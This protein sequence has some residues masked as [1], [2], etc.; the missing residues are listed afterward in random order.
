MPT[1]WLT[2]SHSAPLAQASHGRSSSPGITPAATG[3]VTSHVLPWFDHLVRTRY[4][5]AVS[6]MYTLSRSSMAKSPSAPIVLCRTP[7]GEGSSANDLPFDEYQAGA[8]RPT[9]SAP[10]M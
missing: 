1:P 7:A 9:V 4:G 3:Y 6:I 5:T 8:G 2:N 10:V